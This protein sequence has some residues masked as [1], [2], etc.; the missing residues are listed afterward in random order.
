MHMSSLGDLSKWVLI[1]Y[2]RQDL[3]TTAYIIVIISSRMVL[4]AMVDISR[5]YVRWCG[6]VGHSC[7]K[8][9]SNTSGLVIPSGQTH[10][11]PNSHILDAMRSH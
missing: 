8:V 5:Y 1:R 3:D 7:I 6:Q 9:F 4:D 10:C 2:K 11:Q